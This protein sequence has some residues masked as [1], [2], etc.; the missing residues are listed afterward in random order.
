MPGGALRGVAV[1]SESRIA[2]NRTNATTPAT[3]PGG[4]A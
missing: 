1:R 3:R 4:R 2:V